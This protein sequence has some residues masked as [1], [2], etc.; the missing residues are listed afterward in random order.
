MKQLL[1]TSIILILFMLTI[2]IVNC[3]EDPM[4]LP[5]P[6]PQLPS[7]LPF[8]LTRADVGT[9]VSQAEV[10]AFTKRITGAWKQADYFNWLYYAIDGMS[11]DN[12]SGMPYY[13]SLYGGV[14]I[15]KSGNTYTFTHQEGN[16]NEN[17]FIGNSIILTNTM[18]A[19]AL[20]G[21]ER[22]GEVANLLARGVS[23]VLMGSVWDDNVPQED[24]YIM[25]RS[26]M[27]QNYT[28]TLDNGKTKIVDWDGWGR[29][30]EAWNT[31]RIN[32]PNNPYWGDIWIQNKRSKD[33]V[34]HIFRLASYLPFFMDISSDSE[35]NEGMQN[36]YNDLQMFAKDIV[37]HGY[38]IRTVTDDGTIIK[39]P[40][41]VDLG[42]FVLYGDEAECTAR[43]SSALLAYGDTQN[44]DCQEGRCDW[45]ELAAEVR[46]FWNARIFRTFH[47]ASIVLSLNN[48]YNEEAKLLL[49][50][51]IAR[52]DDD[53]EKE[54]FVEDESY[55]R[56]DMASFFIQA[57][58]CGM[59]LTSRE[60]ALIHE[61][62]NAAIET[63]NEWE[64]WDM[65]D[66]NIP[67]GNIEHKP[68]GLEVRFEEMTNFFILC[69]SPYTNPTGK[70][71]VD[72]DI[73]SNPSQ[74]GE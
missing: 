49:E 33:D 61:Y 17:M 67:D 59:P 68:G 48:G 36:A 21:E 51:L 40:Q 71:V 23:S 42:N 13:G 9:P 55:Y 3:V 6:T 10:T 73:I 1:M 18:A 43:L 39:L 26:I 32:I 20:L 69:A 15:T 12:P 46:A 58:A 66:P 16:T 27:T 22:I 11:K 63:W 56:R 28:E 7:A 31:D 62:Y 41:N 2:S 29:P 72:C 5:T 4:I 37:D 25:A 38:F 24:R 65:F 8:E 19:Y 35:I 45:Y 60:V 50:G 30:S 53:F 70:A 34:C 44:V 74:W 47:I 57:A 14:E 52:N 54:Y 64:Y